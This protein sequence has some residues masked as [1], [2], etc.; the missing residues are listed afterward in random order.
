[1]KKK[2]AAG[3]LAC[4]LTVALLFAACGSG[5]TASGTYATENGTAG[6]AAAPQTAMASD[7][8]AAESADKAAGTDAGTG[9]LTDTDLAA[10]QT[11]RKIIYTAT[12]EM[13]AL[14]FDAT[15][16]ALKQA[17]ATAKGYISYT[18]VSAYHDTNSTRSASYEC[19]VPVDSY[20]AFLAA[21]GSAG[22][23]VSQSEQAQD[24]TR[25]YVDVQARLDSLKTQEARLTEMMQQAG[26]LDTLLAIQNQL[27]E[28]QYQI[29]SY[30]AQQR[31][32]DD[33]VAYC[34]VTV[35][36]T[37][38]AQETETSDDFLSRLGASFRSGW[39]GFVRGC[40]N[41]AVWFVGALPTLVV[42]AILGVIVWRIVRAASRRHAARRAEKQAQAARNM[43]MYAY[44][45]GQPYM[46]A[47]GMPGVPVQPAAPAP[48]QTAADTAKTDAK[49]EA[50][51]Q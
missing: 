20:A 18:N 16:T 1:M 42:L 25:D 27:T 5:S 12:L 29:E 28:V 37:E 7:N 19:R 9:S 50:K 48:A 43:P 14:D 45:A 15:C 39:S 10:A 22:N 40:Q 49:P 47:P 17:V 2:I 23:V 32:Y 44:P 35:D 13:E 31:T 33:Q 46:P 6:N 3:L 8:T 34:T 26:D 51:K 4:L 36:I 11:N 38:V 21:L 41:F 30:T 24:I